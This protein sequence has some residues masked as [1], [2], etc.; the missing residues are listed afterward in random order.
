MAFMSTLVIGI[1]AAHR[2]TLATQSSVYATPSNLYWILFLCWY[3]SVWAVITGYCLWIWARVWEIPELHNSFMDGL[4]ASLFFYHGLSKH[5]RIVTFAMGFLLGGVP[6]FFGAKLSI[7]T[8]YGYWI[9]PF[10]ILPVIALSLGGAYYAMK[11]LDRR[12]V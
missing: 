3:F 5:H 10:L 11:I 12:S 1:L 4:V 6:S 2:I 7:D 8:P 9:A